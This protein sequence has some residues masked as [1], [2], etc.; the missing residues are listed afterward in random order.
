M[1][2]KFGASFKVLKYEIRLQSF[3]FDFEDEQIIPTF[4]DTVGAGEE[5]TGGGKMD[6]PL[7]GVGCRHILA[8]TSG[9]H[10][11]MVVM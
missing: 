5:L 2:E 4:E 10:S 9:G 3:R 8:P 1:G 7:P 6:E 11:D